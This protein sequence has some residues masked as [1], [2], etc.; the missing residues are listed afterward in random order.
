MPQGFGSLVHNCRV[1]LWGRKWHP[2]EKVSKLNVSFFVCVVEIIKVITYLDDTAPSCLYSGF[3]E[4][5]FI[6]FNSISENCQE[7]LSHSRFTEI[8]L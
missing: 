2:I 1:K 6:K 3:L 7:T 5:L 8:W 4:P